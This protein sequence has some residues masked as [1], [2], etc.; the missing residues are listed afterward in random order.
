M[1]KKVI[2]TSPAG[3]ERKKLMN[4]RSLGVHRNWKKNENKTRLLES[5]APIA[6]PLFG[7]DLLTW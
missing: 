2:L 6:P 5:I 3:K 7:I 4:V 1:G